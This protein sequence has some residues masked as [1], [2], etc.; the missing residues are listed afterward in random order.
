MEPMRIFDTVI[1]DSRVSSRV[2]LKCFRIV[3]EVDRS[4]ATEVDR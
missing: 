1:K 3:T 4:D 2:K